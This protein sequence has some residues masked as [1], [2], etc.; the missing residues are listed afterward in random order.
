MYKITGRIKGIKM[1]NRKIIKRLLITHIML[2][3]YIT[4]MGV[5]SI[6]KIMN[7]EMFGWEVPLW[8]ILIIMYILELMSTFTFQLR[9][10]LTS[11]YEIKG[12]KKLIEYI[13][14]IAGA[15]WMIAGFQGIIF[16]TVGLTVNSQISEIE[17]AI[18]KLVPVFLATYN[19]V[20][21]TLIT[22][23]KKEE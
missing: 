18:I 14:L 2:I 17:L 13:P 4:M 9:I 15:S 16:L 1:R 22:K 3:L 19:G 10:K 11:D 21:T 6:Y 7:V 5:L 23:K 12:N 20:Y 8:S